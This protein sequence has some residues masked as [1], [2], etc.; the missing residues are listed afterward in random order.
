MS[1]FGLRVRHGGRRDAVT[2]HGAF[3]SFASRPRQK[4]RARSSFRSATLAALVLLTA[5]CASTSPP[6]YVCRPMMSPD[7]ATV[8]ICQPWDIDQ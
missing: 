4:H 7:G 2:G 5:A 1:R 3:S 8:V 6:V